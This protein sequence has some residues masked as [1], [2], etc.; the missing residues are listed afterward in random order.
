MKN[1]PEIIEAINDYSVFRD[2][3][4]PTTSEIVNQVMANKHLYEVKFIESHD[5][6][7]Q[8]ERGCGAPGGCC[9]TGRCHELVP[10][11]EI[12]RMINVNYHLVHDFVFTEILYNYDEYIEL[13]H[14]T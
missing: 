1:I 11:T 7:T 2:N 6:P 9:C 8:K 12:D 14:G 3:K 13:V 5:G 4:S 10:I